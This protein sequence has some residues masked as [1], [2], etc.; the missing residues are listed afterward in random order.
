MAP[1]HNIV[2]HTEKNSRAEY[3]RVYIGDVGSLEA[4]ST[5]R[6]RIVPP[7]C[8]GQPPW[9]RRKGSVILL[10][11]IA[12]KKWKKYLVHLNFSG[13]MPFFAMLFLGCEML[14]SFEVFG[15]SGLLYF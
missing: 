14:Q 4:T 8:Q 9:M 13:E 5:Q 11:Y 12:H 2:L 6:E 1:H 7:S 10:G 15:L 3:C